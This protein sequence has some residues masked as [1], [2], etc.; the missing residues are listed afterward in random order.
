MAHTQTIY[1]DVLIGVNL[2]INYFLLLAVARF[3]SISVKRRRLVAAAALGAFYA[4]S[5]F[6]PEL[7]SVLSLLVKLAM[8]ATIVLA[9]FPRRT[10]KLFLRELACFYITNFAFAGFMLCLWFFIAPQGL[11]IKNSVVYFEISPLFLLV[12]TVLCYLIIRVIQ[13]VTGRQNPS[14]LFCRIWIDYKGATGVCKAKVD[15]GN[16]LVEPFSGFPV[17]VVEES[18]FREILPPEEEQTSFRVVPF[19]TVSGSGIL[20]AFRPDKL[21]IL[22]GEKK[23]EAKDVYIAVSRESLSGGDFSALLNPDL[24]S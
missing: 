14:L 5:I 22:A 20:P 15:T 2:F 13:R 9:A 16:T 8:S 12:V 6:F 1:L 23:I 21:V 17:V 18:A 11:L 10:L 4:L 3:L 19:Q 24:L 7:P